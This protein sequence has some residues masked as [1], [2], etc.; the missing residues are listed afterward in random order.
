MCVKVYLKQY[1][2]NRITNYNF[3]L[4]EMHSNL[5]QIKLFLFLIKIDTLLLYLYIYTYIYIYIYFIHVRQISYIF[6]QDK[7]KI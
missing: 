5:R 4:S 1:V 6:S 7:G 2:V 3:V